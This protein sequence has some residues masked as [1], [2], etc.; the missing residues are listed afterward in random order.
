MAK[1]MYGIRSSIDR[2]FL[3]HEITITG[4]GWQAKPTPVK[5]LLFYG[6]GILFIVW[7][8]S[9]TFIGK[10]SFGLIVLYVLWA[11][12][13][14]I[15]FGGTTKTK[16]LRLMT[17]PALLAYIPKSAR[18]VYTRM[19]ADPSDFYSIVG[20]QDIDEDGH[21]S[22]ADGGAGQVYLVVGSA[23]AMLFDDDRIGIL[24]RVGA[25]WQKVPVGAEHQFITT[26]EPQRVHKQVANLERRNIGLDV[27]DPDLIELMDEQYSILTEHVGGAFNSIHQYVLLR[28]KSEDKLH[29]AHQV[30]QAEAEGSGLMVKELTALERDET[31]AVLRVLYT[32]VEQDHFSKR[33]K[34]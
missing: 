9:S 17:L 3:D 4:G 24:D 21:I 12:F 13:V 1:D 25:F 22:F 14:V 23:S 19:S 6:A 29:Q 32:G 5:Q 2:S 16:D 11:L 8:V 27:R 28:A 10:A 34:R 7:S 20:I 30:L 33:Q 26:T 15:Y 18:R 31:N